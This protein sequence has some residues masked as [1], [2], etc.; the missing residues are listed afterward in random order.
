MEKRFYIGMA[1][2]LVLLVLGIG[3]SAGMR[4][5]HAPV[6]ERVR[7]VREFYGEQDGTDEQIRARILKMDKSRAAYYDCF[8]QARW[9]Q[10]R[11]YHI[12]LDSSMG[13]DTAVEVLKT[14]AKE[15]EKG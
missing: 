7:R 5:I 4:A 13:L 2:L 9:G 6:E 10:A 3:V 15:K 8:A 14:V 12:T 11:N 1:I